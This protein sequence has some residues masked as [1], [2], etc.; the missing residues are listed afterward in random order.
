MFY[1]SLSDPERVHLVVAFTFELSKVTHPAVRERE[2]IVPSNVDADL[3]AF[4][5][6]GLSPPPR[7][8]EPQDQGRPV[9][10]LASVRCSPSSA[11][12]LACPEDE[13]QLP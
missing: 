8:P 4:V 9:K 5:A 6:D 12:R 11:R 2:L 10:H 1:A 13:C 7:R 3:C